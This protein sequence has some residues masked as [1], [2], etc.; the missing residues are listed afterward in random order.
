MNVQIRHEQIHQ[1]HS[2]GHPSGFISAV[3]GDGAQG[4]L[5]T[6]MDSSLENLRALRVLTQRS[7]VLYLRVSSALACRATLAV[8]SF[9]CKVE[10]MIT[11]PQ[12]NRNH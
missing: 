5:L 4:I 7:E 2:D 10:M 9:G 3:L 1:L 12:A 11:T 8:N 6:L